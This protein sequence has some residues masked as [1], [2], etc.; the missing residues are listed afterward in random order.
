MS[1]ILVLA[2]ILVLVLTTV[3]VSTISVIILIVVVSPVIVVSTSRSSPLISVSLFHIQ[4]I[5]FLGIIHNL[6]IV[7]K[8]SPQLLF[9][10]KMLSI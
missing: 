10:K 6:Y 9:V 5:L 3:I 1:L 8:T 7:S 4:D 2:L